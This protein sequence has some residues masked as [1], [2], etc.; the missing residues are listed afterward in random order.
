M[1]FNP[2]FTPAQIL[3]TLT[4]AALLVLLVVLLGRN[5]ARLFPWFTASIV[6]M[7][8]RLLTSRMLLGKLPMFTMNAIFITLADIT[9]LVG[10]MVVVEMARRSFSGLPRQL[11]IVNGAGL[12]AL[13][14]TVLAVWGPWPAWKTLT[15]DS[16]LATLRLMQMAAQKGDVL[17]T[18][19]TVGVGL[20]AVLFGSRYNAGWR[21]H[22][23]RILIGLSTAGIAQL[24]LIVELQRIAKTAAPNTQAELDR[25]LAFRDNL[26]NAES[27]VYVV[28]LVWWIVCLWID[29]P[30]ANN[31][32]AELPDGE[33]Q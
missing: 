8:L 9:A 5:R 28:V 15:A 10:L 24:A 14:G 4:F 21:S 13:A 30:G 1:H 33:T 18:I 3:W 12:L 31:E 23:Q 32:P 16:H 2:A 25:I 19:L 6:L 22:A 7:A 17:V 20:L 29:E 27:A 11:W 26:I